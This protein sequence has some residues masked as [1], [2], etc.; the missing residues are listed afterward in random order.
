MMIQAHGCY[1][2]FCLSMRFSSVAVGFAGLG[3]QP[4]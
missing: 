4:Y 1:V 2:R 3:G